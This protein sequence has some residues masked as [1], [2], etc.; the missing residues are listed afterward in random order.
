MNK[1]I[2]LVVK[3]M[4]D[5]ESVTKQEL[6]DNSDE[7]YAVYDVAIYDDPADYNAYA[8]YAAAEAAE[9]AHTAAY[10]AIYKYAVANTE[11]YL[12]KYF[13]QSGETEQDY[14]DEIGET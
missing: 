1:H 5:T 11:K 2:L 7:A 10:A 6:T 9:A 13:E 14:I 8:A 3:W 12:S 4:Q